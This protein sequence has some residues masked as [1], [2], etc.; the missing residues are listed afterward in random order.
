MAKNNLSLILV[1]VFISSPLTAQEL[2]VTD[3]GAVPDSLTLNT[4]AIQLAIDKCNQS[5][6]GTVIVPS[7]LYLTGSIFLKTMYA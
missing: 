3:F 2:S 5:G 1:C 4:I 7:G 6:G